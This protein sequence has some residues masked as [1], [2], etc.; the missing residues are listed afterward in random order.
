[1]AKRNGVC[2][3]CW[4][5]Q[6]ERWGTLTDPNGKRWEI[7]DE[8]INELWHL[9]DADKQPVQEEVESELYPETQPIPFADMSEADIQKLAERVSAFMEGKRNG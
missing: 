7:C 6:R 5:D 1:M 4:R 9:H 3:C 2:P 8:C